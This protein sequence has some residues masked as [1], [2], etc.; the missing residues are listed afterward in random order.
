MKKPRDY[1]KS[2]RWYNIYLIL[3]ASLLLAALVISHGE[4]DK[5]YVLTAEEVVVKADLEGEM[6]SL[7]HMPGA[8]YGRIN[9]FNKNHSFRLVSVTFDTTL[10]TETV[11]GHY[12]KQLKAHGWVESPGDF[13]L[14]GKYI[15]YK[16]ERYTAEIGHVSGNQFSIS[17]EWIKH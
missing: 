5:P 9:S 8:K 1:I 3:L 10:D 7:Q 4:I 14:W 13:H 12:D 2:N 6:Q 11:I 16:K 17:F 15:H